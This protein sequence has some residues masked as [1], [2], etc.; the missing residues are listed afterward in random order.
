MAWIPHKEYH[1]RVGGAGAAPMEGHPAP[2]RRNV[3]E[4]RPMTPLA[5]PLLADFLMYDE[6]AALRYLIPGD[7]VLFLALAGLLLTLLLDVRPR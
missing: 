5:G 4:D 3:P 6:I 1:E 7:F 2:A